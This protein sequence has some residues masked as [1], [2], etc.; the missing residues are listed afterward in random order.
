MRYS[1]FRGVLLFTAQQQKKGT[2]LSMDFVSRGSPL[3]LLSLAAL[4]REGNDVPFV[5]GKVSLD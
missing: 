2:H 5:G 1:F 3:P 4:Y